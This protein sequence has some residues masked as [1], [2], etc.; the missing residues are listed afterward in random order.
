MFEPNYAMDQAGYGTDPSAGGGAPAADP[1]AP[2][3]P[4]TTG[5]QINSWYQTYLGHDMGAGTPDQQRIWA[6][7]ANTDPN[8]VEQGIANSPEAMAYMASK[9]AGSGAAAPAAAP[10]GATPTLSQPNFN[11]DRYS[12][13]A[14]PLASAQGANPALGQLRSLLMQYAG[15]SDQ[16]DPNSPEIQR[17]ADAY[18]ADVTRAGR[19]FLSGAAESAG[20]YA[21]MGARAQSVAEKAGQATA[22]YRANLVAQMAAARRQQIAGAL[23]GLGGVLNTDEA[24]RLRQEDQDLARSQAGAQSAQQA[25]ADQ[26]QTIFG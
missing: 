20:P 18:G 21:D 2:T 12:G 10:G 24:T 11:G 4:K 13:G 19:S 25:F 8:A 26:Y 15:Q 23:S 17:Q 1:T 22:D 7:W 6:Q 16:V 9:N 5:S 3:Q 14:A